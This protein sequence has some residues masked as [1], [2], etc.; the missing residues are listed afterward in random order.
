MN[1]SENGYAGALF[2][3]L[4]SLAALFKFE[5]ALGWLVGAVFAILSAICLRVALIKSAQAVE[6]D[7]QR[8]EIQ[9]QQLRN[10][11]G[12]VAAVNVE[13]MDSIVDAAKLAQENLQVIRVRLAELDNLTQIA[14]D[15]QKLRSIV[16]N[17][18]ENFSMINSELE[19]L[20]AIAVDIRENLKTIHPTKLDD[21]NQPSPNFSELNSELKRLN[22][23]ED[24]NKAN[25]QTILKLLQVVAQ[26]LNNKPYSKDL[27]KINS[28]LAALA[29]KIK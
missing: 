25:L 6:E 8:L 5:D 17:P 21:F 13:S 23:I 12:E 4:M 22:V 20:S 28:S 18:K 2:F 15:S 26:L 29:E 1:G 9:F 16:T 14:E 11:V 27:E 7:H 10:K 19:K 24:V 3:A